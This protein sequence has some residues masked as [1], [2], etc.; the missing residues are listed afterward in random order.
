MKTFSALAAFA[1][2]GVHAASLSPITRVVDLLKGLSVKI[3]EE[4]KTEESLY[5]KFVCWGKTT[6]DTKTASNAAADER[7]KSLKTYV[8]D[9]EAGRIEFTTERVD[10]EKEIAQ[11][12]SDIETAT[13][14]RDQEKK[15]FETA[16]KEMDQGIAAL[17]EAISV[18]SEATGDKKAAGL[19]AVKG[20]AA[21]GFAARSQQG[22]LLEHA[23]DLGER[24]LSKGD[25]RF[26]S[27]LLL[28]NVQPI[29]KDWKKLNRK[30]TFKM[31]Y[32]ARSG[33]IQDTLAK[34]LET[35][36]TNLDEAQ[37]KE[38]EA[39]E[40]FDKL[41][42]SKGD[43]KK[44]AEESLIT[45][46]KESGARGMTVEQ[47]KAEVE[48]LEKQVT[49]DTKYIEDTQKALDEKKDEWKARQTLRAQ[50][51][52][53][54]SKAIAILHSDDARD[55]FKKSLS[56]Q[57]YSLL[58]ISEKKSGSKKSLA[59]IF[60][61]RR[62]ATKANDDRLIALAQR[63]TA[64]TSGGFDEVI[65]AID[66]MISTLKDEEAQELKTKE[67]CE[68]TR[69]DDVKD[70]QVASRTVDELTDTKDR[71]E[72]EIEEIEGEIKDKNK[73]IDTIK[74]E[75]EKA[76]ANRE[77]EA[78]AYAVAKADDEAAV[79]LIEQSHS[80]LQSFYADNGL[81]LISKKQGGKQAPTV[82][83]GE[84]P[85]PP[86]S[87][88]DTAEYGGKTGES[89]GILSILDM[90][91][92]DIKKDISKA[93]TAEDEAIA[94]YDTLKTDLEQQVTDL[95]TAISDLE[96]TKSEKEGEV[97]TT[98]EERET[99]KGELKATMKKIKD[100]EAGCDFITVNFELRTSNRQIEVDGLEKAK[101]ILSGAEFS[102]V[103]A[104][105]KKQL[106]V[107]RHQ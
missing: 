14:L 65:K 83:A 82:A 53:A 87:T 107:R 46:E 85:P 23:V 40:L 74:E 57:G 7:I 37:K 47:A 36:K 78:A 30:S 58:Q 84:A 97:Q 99:K 45:M 38:D 15:D 77:A 63:L 10:L 3:E 28:G 24:I 68:Q 91:K 52:E 43:Q 42:E 55:L 25:A 11:L 32:K 103:Q 19:L 62:A 75:L 64:Q 16:K 73:E 81:M 104:G 22:A 6:I 93:T 101:A 76:K 72:T 71:L 29:N 59:A 17:E 67:K 61:L 39:Q 4:G 31:S 34:L 41:M 5:N 33:E 21:A 106:A 44:K 18:L 92:E 102:A 95:E 49:D 48:D 79:S 96:G 35:F 20:K 1:A 54:V 27:H 2:A 80:V 89:Q 94:A 70:A 26:L 50:E 90:I 100:Y 13:S 56:S 105:A 69:A 98:I 86:P 9:I 51:V 88:W 12:A 60:E 8:A 66:D